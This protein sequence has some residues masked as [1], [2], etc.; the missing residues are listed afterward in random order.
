MEY[1]DHLRTGLLLEPRGHADMYG[2]ILTASQDPR[3]DLDCFFINTVG[4]S[5]MCGHATLA[6]TKVAFETGVV[7]K[8][9][10]ERSLTIAVPAGLV[11]AK[12]LVAGDGSVSKTIFRNVP[13]FVYIRDQAVAVPALGLEEVKFDIAF[14]GAFY[15]STYASSSLSTHIR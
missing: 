3:A 6:I 15:A 1:Y 10:V 13:S 5:T 11:Y 12:A 7:K 4:Y 14:G 8:E 9:G 2:A